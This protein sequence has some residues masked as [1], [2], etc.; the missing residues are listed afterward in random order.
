[1]HA[2]AIG[3][4]VR[5]ALLLLMAVLWDVNWG[6][7]GLVAT[8]DRAHGITM[9]VCGGLMKVSQNAWLSGHLDLA[10]GVGVV[11][12]QASAGQNSQRTSHIAVILSELPSQPF[13]CGHQQAQQPAHAK[14]M[15]I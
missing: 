15:T 4:F 2:L 12:C 5:Y 11:Q 10:L 13:I 1:L 7:P 3:F 9:R 14:G 6:N 8:S